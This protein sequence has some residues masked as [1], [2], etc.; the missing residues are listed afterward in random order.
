ME[1]FFHKL[2]KKKKEM[3]LCSSKMIWICLT[4][5]NSLRVLQNFVIMSKK[6]AKVCKDWPRKGKM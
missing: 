5:L 2:L 4:H 1:D 6:G 3:D